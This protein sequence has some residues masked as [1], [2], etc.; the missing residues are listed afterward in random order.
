MSLGEHLPENVADPVVPSRAVV[1]PFRVKIAEELGDEHAR[2]VR[3]V[4]GLVVALRGGA[5]E[6]AADQVA[7][8][9]EVPTPELHRCPG[10]RREE[11]EASRATGTR[12]SILGIR[13]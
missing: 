12:A 9:V 1:H 3:E 10:R 2:S 11:Y 4:G 6:I 7:E 13:E 5:S 8:S